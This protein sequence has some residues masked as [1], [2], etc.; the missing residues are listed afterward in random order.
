MY[1]KE[2]EG[3]LLAVS[4][5]KG[6][7]KPTPSPQNPN[8]NPLEFTSIILLK[9]VTG[10]TAINLTSAQYNIP[11]I[12]ILDSAGTE[13]SYKEKVKRLR[14]KI[15]GNETNIPITMAYLQKGLMWSPA[16]LVELTDDKTA[17]ITMQGLLS[18]DVEDIDNA[19]V[20]FVVGYPNFMYSDLLSPLAL[21]QSVTSFV[22]TI[23]G[24]E[25]GGRR[26]PELYQSGLA[27][28]AAGYNYAPDSRPQSDFD[29][30]TTGAATG[31]QEEDL[32]LYKVK[33]VSLKSGERAYCTIFSAE[34]PYEHVY[35]LQ[36]PDQSVVDRFG[37]LDSSRILPRN[38]EP[39][40][41]HQLKIKNTSA[42]P[43]TTAP[44]MAVS[45]NN[46][47]SQDRLDYTPVGATGK[48]KLTVAADIKS[49]QSEIE[50]SRTNNAIIINT[51][52]YTKVNV[53]GTIT[54]K[55]FKSKPVKVFVKKTLTGEAVTEDQGG[56]AQ[57]LAAAIQAV[58]PV[59]EVSWELTLNPGEEKTLNYSY[60][61]YIH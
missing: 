15:S 24:L 3:Q 8:P 56:K 11:W 25:P 43:W 7:E 30:S 38:N 23:T 60:F 52:S 51:I 27:N 54:L 20:S 28:Q 6:R 59:S 2:F 12:E 18:N 29:Y 46:P 13:T 4:D 1:G 58:N 21:T 9:T 14:F 41:W 53:D 61:V 17:R 42:Y 31:T 39:Q 32:F 57:K 19:D 50:K 33:N 34:V 45:D 16:Y 26:A 37:N 35:D 55:S 49:K 44:A 40:V 47:L 36:I 48:L 10:T 22:S 5:N